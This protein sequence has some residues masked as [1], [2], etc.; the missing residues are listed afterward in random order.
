MKKYWTVFKISFQQEFAYPMNFIMWRI[1]NVIQ[2]FLVFFLWD[3][4]FS[5]STTVLFGYDRSKILTYVF[6]IIIVRSIVLSMRSVDVAG[7]ISRGDL[8]NYLVK[9]I[10]YLKYWFTR[11]I[12]S[13]ALNVSFASVEV[14]IL[15]FI[16]KPPFFF[17]TNLIYLGM[18][19]IA[20]VLAI[21]LYFF[22][23]FMFSMLTFVQPEQAW[24]AVFILMILV[25]SL[26]GGL[27][28]VDILPTNI[29]NI[30][31]L[32]PF[33]YL[34]FAPLE[35][36]LA[37]FGFVKSIQMLGISALWVL[38]L[39]LLTNYLWKKGVKHY[40]AEGR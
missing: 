36:Y 19:L 38:I 27:L 22:L 4:V 32:L 10:N 11:D 33:P 34:L 29:Q 30:L 28:P 2:I 14:I 18:F 6:G 16:L 5:N 25:D 7:E 20:V 35:I 21:I 37:K 1:R 8:S 26:G 3:T 23:L 39:A 12:A 9:P 24:G 40:R 15:F 31:Y 13:K 17:Q